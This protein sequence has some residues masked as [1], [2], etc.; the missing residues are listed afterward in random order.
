MSRLLW[1]I[2][3]VSLILTGLVAV[4][5]ASWLSGRYAVPP[6]ERLWPFLLTTLVYVI[7]LVAAE[8]HLAHRQSVPGFKEP[9]VALLAMAMVSI[10]LRRAAMYMANPAPVSEVF[11][12]T[13]ALGSGGYHNAAVMVD[14]LPG[15]L[16]QFP[17]SMPTWDSHPKTHPPDLPLSFIGWRSLLERF[18]GMAPVL[19]LPLR[20]NQC[21]NSG[22][23]F[24][25]DAQL[26]SAFLV[27]PVYWLGRAFY[28]P[29]VAGWAAAWIRLSPSLIVFSS[30][31]NQFYPLLLTGALLSCWFGFERRGILWFFASGLLEVLGV[32]H[33]RTS[34]LGDHSG[35][36][37]RLARPVSR[38]HHGR[39][40]PGPRG[41]HCLPPAT[42]GRITAQDPF[43]LA[44][45]VHLIV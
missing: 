43:S 5:S 4:D 27:W 3:A 10:V 15:F 9:A 39:C 13:A 18:P 35:P 29:H 2:I 14:D 32:R 42:Q 24:L 26:A 21:H 12:R 33:G 17:A 7:L 6:L 1:V 23:M 40:H 36:C 16:R 38:S 41:P 11:R 8:R 44:H 25:G 30:T 31:R 19:A 34:T 45:A 20:L 28:R 22:L 37:P